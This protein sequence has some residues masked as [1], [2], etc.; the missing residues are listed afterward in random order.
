MGGRFAPESQRFF[1]ESKG[2]LGIAIAEFQ[3]SL[4][5]PIVGISGYPRPGGGFPRD[6]FTR[7]R[8]SYTLPRTWSRAQD[9]Q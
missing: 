6:D 3:P 1:R 9:S 4:Q 8:S 7:A 2:F 5:A